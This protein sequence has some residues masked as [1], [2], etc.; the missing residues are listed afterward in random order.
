MTVV[1]F[2]ARSKGVDHF[3][4]EGYLR[5]RIPLHSPSPFLRPDILPPNPSVQRDSARESE[6]KKEKA[7]AREKEGGVQR[8]RERK[9]KGV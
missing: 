6:S 9:R 2:L 5:I 1:F 3:Y 7:R 8:D 4:I